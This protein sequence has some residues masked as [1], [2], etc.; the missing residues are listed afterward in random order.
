MDENM[1]RVYGIGLDGEKYHINSEGKLMPINIESPKIPIEKFMEKLGSRCFFRG[2]NVIISSIE[3]FH[4]L[5]DLDRQVVTIEYCDPVSGDNTSSNID[6]ALFV[7]ECR[8]EDITQEKKKAFTWVTPQEKEVVIAV[9]RQQLD[10]AP[11]CP[12][13]NSL[14]ILLGQLSPESR[15][16]EIYD[17]YRMVNNF[18]QKHD[19]PNK[20]SM[21]DYQKVTEKIQTCMRNKENTEMLSVRPLKTH[22]NDFPVLVEKKTQGVIYIY[23]LNTEIQRLQGLNLTQYGGLYEVKPSAPVEVFVGNDHLVYT[24]DELIKTYRFLITN[25]YQERTDNIVTHILSELYRDHPRIKA[26]FQKIKQGGRDYAW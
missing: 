25:K 7:E 14:L 5:G 20:Q 10:E 21:T 12:A 13:K 24:G 22:E 15:S 23:V 8:F 26:V 19:L 2:A 11:A 3:Q 17:I 6:Y 16:T 9:M 1:R 18:V 4:Y